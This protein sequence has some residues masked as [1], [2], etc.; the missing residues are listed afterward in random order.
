MASNPR[1]LTVLAEYNGLNFDT[2]EKCIKFRSQWITK[3]RTE[4]IQEHFTEIQI[5]ILSVFCI[6][7]MKSIPLGTCS[8]SARPTRLFLLMIFLH[9]R[10]SNMAGGCYICNRP[11]RSKGILLVISTP[12][13]YQWWVLSTTF[14]SESWILSGPHIWM[15]VIYRLDPMSD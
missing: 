13:F 15:G 14:I 11:Y 4:N 12:L 10:I 8:H 2:R 6:H 7:Q 5:N 3:P 1:A 9:C